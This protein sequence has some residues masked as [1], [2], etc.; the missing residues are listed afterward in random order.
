[1]LLVYW[2]NTNK[3]SQ[4][5]VVFI[6]WWFINFV[7]TKRR[8]TN[9]F[10]SESQNRNYSPKI[11]RVVSW[12]L[13]R[14]FPFWGFL[15]DSLNVWSY[16]A[17]V[18]FVSESCRAEWVRPGDSPPGPPQISSLRPP[19]IASRAPTC[20]TWRASSYTGLGPKAYPPCPPAN[21]LQH[22]IKRCTYH[23]N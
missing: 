16:E 4:I 8:W 5:D 1:M 14:T 20:P 11:Q 9:T 2:K 6:L 15:V 21:L 23:S 13:L 22:A 19:K 3:L 12:T 10:N 18:L 17:A 7:N